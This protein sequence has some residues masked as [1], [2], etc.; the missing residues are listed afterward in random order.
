MVLPRKE[1]GAPKR[2]ASRASKEKTAPEVDEAS[3]PLFEKLRA[4]R[5]EVARAKGGP[6]YIVAHDRTLAELAV[7]K[8]RTLADLSTIHGFGPARIEQYGEGFLAIIA[9]S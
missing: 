2:S 9:D 3:R 1:I 4:H 5:A 7:R 6:A 8:P